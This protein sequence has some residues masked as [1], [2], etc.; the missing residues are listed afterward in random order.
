M[1]INFRQVNKLFH[2]GLIDQQRALKREF[3]VPRLFQEKRR[4]LVFASLSLRPSI[5]PSFH[6]SVLPT[7][8]EVRTLRAQLLLQFYTNSFETSLVFWSWSEDIHVV[9]I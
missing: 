8:I 5:R 3:I 2:Q 9:W 4:D 1:I 6:P 7:P